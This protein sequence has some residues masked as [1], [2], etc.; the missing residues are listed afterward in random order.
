MRRTVPGSP[1]VLGVPAAPPEPRVAKGRAT[2]TRLAVMATD[3]VTI[4]AAMF[5]A[6]AVWVPAHRGEPGVDSGIYLQVIGLSLP[7]WIAIFRHYRLYSARHISSHRQELGRVVHGVAMSVVAVALVGQYRGV[8]LASGWLVLVFSFTVV[9]VGVE[10]ELLRLVFA[11]L[12]RRGHT[13]RPVAIAGV[14]AEARALAAMIEEQPELGYRVVAFVCDGA[15]VDDSLSRP[16]VEADAEVGDNLRSVGAA[17]VI[18]AATDLG[19]TTANRLI[20]RLTDS[21]LHVELSSS[22]KDIDAG[23]LSIRALGHFSVVYVEPVH[24]NGWRPAAKRTFDVVVASLGL[25]VSLPVLAVAIVAIRVTSPGPALFR[26]ERVG[27]RGKRF[28]I[29]KLRSMYVDGDER[30]RALAV[31]VPDGPVPKMTGDPRVTPVG[32]FLRKS[33]LDELPQ[34]INVIRGEMSLVGPRP[35]QPCEVVLWTPEMFDRLRARPGLTGV[36]QVSGRSQSRDTKD[37]WDLYYVDNWSIWRDIVIL[38]KT[39]PV[40]L[41]SKGA[42]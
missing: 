22:L 13:L 6:Y 11:T 2:V 16:V 33:S 7:L 5:A 9:A 34:L 24:R 30:L 38:V 1:P 12:R 18:V 36:W 31:E 37:R 21:G 26:Q 23:R 8:L 3:L 19:A 39:I 15:A 10:R 35:E 25:L 41:F 28:K 20:R 40:V 29:F 32:R 4:A 17:G 42:Y 27:R 14:G